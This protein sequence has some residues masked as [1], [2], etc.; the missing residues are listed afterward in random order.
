MKAVRKVKALALF[1]ALVALGGLV[2]NA[3]TAETVTAKPCC[4]VMVCT[5]MPPIV[6]WEVCAPCPPLPPPGP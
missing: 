2:F 3:V 4:W 5:V 6:C 1:L